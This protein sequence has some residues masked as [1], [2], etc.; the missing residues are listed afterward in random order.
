MKP[1]E[2][3]SDE[4]AER[5]A[6]DIESA[7]FRRGVIAAPTA[8]GGLG[9]APARRCQD[10]SDLIGSLW[11]GGIS[12]LPRFHCAFLRSVC[13]ICEEDFPTAHGS[14][15]SQ[16]VLL[17]LLSAHIFHS[18]CIPAITWDFRSTILLLAPTR[19]TRN[20]RL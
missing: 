9:C 20:P 15:I 13:H 3:A 1:R 16:P 7:A 10:V 5:I 8:F 12:N 6:D 19:L 14:V 11:A 2:G 18:C 17:R 4:L